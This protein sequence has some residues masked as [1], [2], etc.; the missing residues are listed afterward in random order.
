MSYT[1]ILSYIFLFIGIAIFYPSFTVNDKKGI[2]FGTSI[3]LIAIVLFAINKFE[4][5]DDYQLLIPSLIF[6]LSLS[7][8]MIFFSDNSDIKYLILAIIMAAIASFSL[9]E[10]GN[11]T[12][13]SFAASLINFLGK[14]W[15]IVILSALTIFLL[16]ADRKKKSDG[17]GP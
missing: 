17:S 10:R 13:K 11:P 9:I 3:F 15:I 2:F 6:I 1:E 5:I 4:M 8:L 7:F 16:S 12:L 14:Y